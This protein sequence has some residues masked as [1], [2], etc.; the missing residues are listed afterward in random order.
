[1]RKLTLV[2]V[3]S[4]LEG[5][6]IF[7]LVNSA[8]HNSL[9]GALNNLVPDHWLSNSLASQ[10]HNKDKDLKKAKSELKKKKAQLT[11]ARNKVSSTRTKIQK[12]VARNLSANIASIPAESIPVIGIATIVAVT[13]MD[14]NDAC[15]TM[16]DLDD[17]TMSLGM[18]DVG[19][20]TTKV[21]G[22]EVPSK[23]KV[24]TDLGVDIAAYQQFKRDYQEWETNLGGFLH[25]FFHGSK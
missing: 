3:F 10:S 5:L 25:D 23:E 13:A 8:F 16:S 1:M 19:P 22:E 7:S 6:N 4:G 14:L 11:S 20:Q 9:F 15:E 18:D 21:C 2:L 12:R 17:L 24:M